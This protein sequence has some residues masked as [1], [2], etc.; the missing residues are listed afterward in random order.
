MLYN[1]YNQL[2]R[3]AMNSKFVIKQGIQ[4]PKIIQVGIKVKAENAYDFISNTTLVTV[5]LEVLPKSRVINIK[6]STLLPYVLLSGN[7]LESFFEKLMPV[8][9]DRLADKV[10]VTTYDAASNSLGVTLKATDAMP[11]AVR[12]LWKLFESEIG[13]FSME[14]SFKTNSF[15][16]LMNEIVLRSNQFPIAIES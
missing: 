5:L 16:S 6:K 1:K 3:S 11:L 13:S 4:L 12:K 9:L 2:L 15:D 7:K 8:I 14:L 10:V